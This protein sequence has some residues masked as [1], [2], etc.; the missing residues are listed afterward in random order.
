MTP[1]V[2]PTSAPSPTFHEL[3]HLVAESGLPVERR[4]IIIADLDAFLRATSVGHLRPSD[5]KSQQALRRLGRVGS[6]FSVKRGANIRSNVRAAV[7]WFHAQDMPG[8]VQT[9]LPAGEWGAIYGL[10]VPGSVEKR[11]L[12]RFVR[13]C[14]MRGLSSRQLDE[15]TLLE[16]SLHLEDSAACGNI[17]ATLWRVVDAWNEMSTAHEA[18]PR[19]QLILPPLPK[20][21][22]SYDKFAL[23]FMAGLAKYHETATRSAGLPSKRSRF[24]EDRPPEKKRTLGIVRPETSQSRTYCLRR[25]AVLLAQSRSVPLTEI[26]SPDMLIEAGSAQN[27]LDE[28]YDSLGEHSTALHTMAVTFLDFA[29]RMHP[30]KVDAHQRMRNLVAQTK[31]PQPV[32][33]QK[34]RELL[35]ALSPEIFRNLHALPM[36]LLDA[37]CLSLKDGKILTI[38]DIADA[39]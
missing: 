5:K 12:S 7:K 25:A 22:T 19:V 17:R 15:G 23:S 31:G 13:W 18:W 33:T 35:R 1:L 24:Q 14:G 16:Y 20:S 38:Q 36:R 27:I 39:Q 30:E 21:F 6:R 32:M 4:R 3:R 9:G 11:R 28:Y 2:A 8:L 34:N 26:K 37:V 29:R 10:L